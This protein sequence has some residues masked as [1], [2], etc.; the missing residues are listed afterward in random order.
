MQ[1]CNSRHS[2]THAAAA[3]ASK[4]SNSDA[5]P[6]DATAAAAATTPVPN[7]TS[8]DNAKSPV[9]ASDASVAMTVA[10]AASSTASPTP[11]AITL[12]PSLTPAT[13]LP[14]TYIISTTPFPED[15]PSVAPSTTT[16]SSSSRSPSPFHTLATT[17]LST[18][19][20]VPPPS[21]AS[22]VSTLKNLSAN[23]ADFPTFLEGPALDGALEGIKA[24]LETSGAAFASKTTVNSPAYSIKKKKILAEFIEALKAKGDKYN[25]LLFPAKG[26][27]FPSHFPQHIDVPFVF[28][29]LSGREHRAKK[30]K[31]LNGMLIDWVGDK[32]SY[33]TT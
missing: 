4:A 28:V 13:Q 10:T 20:V 8:A 23:L 27:H 25:H 5:N 9:K 19:L 30:V 17:T 18:Q 7:S 1:T 22:T 29:L 33:Q 24:A 3:A 31:I 2:T 32:K 11:E 21:S 6:G 16:P 12:R 14:T 26:K 15:N